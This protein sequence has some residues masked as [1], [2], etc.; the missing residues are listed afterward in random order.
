M[1]V[2]LTVGHIKFFLKKIN[3]KI[4]GLGFLII[5]FVFPGLTEVGVIF[6]AVG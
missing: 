4:N 2:F 1:Y 6:G 3:G 5:N